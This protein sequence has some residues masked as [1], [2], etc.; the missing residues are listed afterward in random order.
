MIVFDLLKRLILA[1]LSFGFSFVVLFLEFLGCGA[2]V[3][4]GYRFLSNSSV[5][6]AS[7]TKF[8]TTFPEDG[9]IVG[10]LSLLAALAGALIFAASCLSDGISAFLFSFRK[11]LTGFIIFG[12]SFI[13]VWVPGVY[14]F[15]M[16]IGGVMGF[17]IGS[18][19]AQMDPQERDRV[20]R[21]IPETVRAFEHQ[22]SLVIM[23]IVALV[24]GRIAWTMVSYLVS[25]ERLPWC[26]YPTLRTR[27]ARSSS[28][29]LPT[30][31]PLPPPAIPATFTA[32][33]LP[34]AG[35]PKA[36]PKP[37]PPKV[38]KGAIAFPPTPSSPAKVVDV[39]PPR[40]PVKDTLFGNLPLDQWPGAN[41]DGSVF[42]W[43][44]FVTARDYLQA[45][46]VPEA[47][48]CWQSII[49]TPSLEVL[50][51]VQAWHFLRQNGVQP[52]EE[53]AKS[54]YGVI[55]EQGKS[56]ILVAAYLDGQARLYDDHGQEVV[57][58][59]PDASL[60]SH[61]ESTLGAA[62]QLVWK[63]KQNDPRLTLS[64]SSTNSISVLTPAGIRFK[65]GAPGSFEATP[66]I[67]PVAEAFGLLTKALLEKAGQLP[68]NLKRA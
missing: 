29:R 38:E 47:I 45:G 7:I 49:A 16:I 27:Q 21:T 52:S 26:R 22:H 28:Q 19:T 30:T 20:M 34:S 40:N 23:G 50:H 25:S 53:E 4:V 36:E 6:L 37:P 32:R 9:K 15:C 33:S 17:R 68:N 62:T 44:E 12:Y 42:P 1:V 64:A 39:K 46:Q 63:M 41:V 67:K 8:S 48:A 60:D 3:D 56:T 2:F 55:S 11:F 18:G 43:S 57:W 65:T 51:Y 58:A 10:I 66:L 24:A 59:H 13:I 31:T 35:V 5:T 54:V 14:L 61:I